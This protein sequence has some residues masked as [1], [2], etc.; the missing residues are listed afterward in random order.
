MHI[1]DTIKFQ[2]IKASSFSRLTVFGKKK[3]GLE[4][5][6]LLSTLIQFE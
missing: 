4:K 5:K 6:G 1:T 2:K 3:E